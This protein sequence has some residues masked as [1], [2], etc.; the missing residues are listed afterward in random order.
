M[1]PI[2]ALAVFALDLWA[3]TSLFGSRT[4]RRARVLWVALVLLVPFAG[5]LLWLL[6]GRRAVPAHTQHP[7]R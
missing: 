1:R 6:R 5:A 3:L 7:A 4:P 2:L